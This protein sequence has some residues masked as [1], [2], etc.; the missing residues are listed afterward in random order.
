MTA[1][2]SINN[3]SIKSQGGRAKKLLDTFHLV[4]NVSFVIETHV[5]FRP[6]KKK[7]P[8]IDTR[9]TNC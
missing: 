1:F 2:H 5:P 9:E 3:Q 6:T 8:L 7:V 4:V